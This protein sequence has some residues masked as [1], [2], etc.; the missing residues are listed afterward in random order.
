MNAIETQDLGRRYGKHWALR[1]CTLQV[2]AGSV[3]AVVGPNGAGKTTLL[4]MLV[5]L[6]PHSEGHL[7]VLGAT[8]SHRAEFLSRVGFVAQDSPLYKEFTVADLMRMGSGMNPMWDDDLA[9]NRLA[10]TKIPLAAKAGRLSGGQKAQVALTLAVAKRPE[11]LVLDEPLASLDPLAR[12]DF[13][14]S[15]MGIAATTG[16]T[17][18][19]SSHLI[20]ELARVCDHLA[21]IAGGELR[22]AGEIDELLEQHRWITGPSPDTERLPSGVQVLARTDFE[23]HS[24]VLVRSDGPVLNPAVNA[25]PVDLEELVLSY[26]EER[27]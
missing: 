5:G 16:V 18:V 21:V 11:L 24:R 2:P 12:R 19:L 23:R 13:L 26:L 14:Q 3:V 20:G 9:K 15:L 17:V 25:S 27:R 6:L 1:H 4:N 7:S 10:A 8:P 22:L